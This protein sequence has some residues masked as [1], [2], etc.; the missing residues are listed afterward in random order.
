VRC[1]GCR[2]RPG[3]PTSGP[4]TPAPA[5]VR[6][7]GVPREYR[8]TGHTR[9][10]GLPGAVE[11]PTRP[12][13]VR[14]GGRAADYRRPPVVASR[15]AGR[16]GSDALDA[17][18]RDRVRMDARNAGHRGI[19]TSPARG[20]VRLFRTRTVGGA[21]SP[22]VLAS[23]RPACRGWSCAG[24]ALLR[25]PPGGGSIKGLG[26][27]PCGLGPRVSARGGLTPAACSGPNPAGASGPRDAAPP[28]PGP[29]PPGGPGPATAARQRPRGRAESS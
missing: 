27:N 23:V 26:W 12:A 1:L 20:R 14:D 13:L 6:P 16:P 7:A 3:Q 11:G 21:A 22:N 29:G 10:A 2:A 5:G 18:R 8:G 24:V 15:H 28:P 17:R 9:A 25:A 4:G 19:G